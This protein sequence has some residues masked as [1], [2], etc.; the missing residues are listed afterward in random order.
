MHKRYKLISD[1]VRLT[2]RFEE[3]VSDQELDIMNFTAWLND[4]VQGNEELAKDE[5]SRT[6]PA[7]SLDVQLSSVVG[8]LYRYAKHYSKKALKDSPL[9]TLDDYVFLATVMIK[10]GMTKSEVIQEHLLEITSGAEI[11]KRLQKHGFIEDYENP[12]DKRSKKLKVTSAG[13]QALQTAQ[14]DMS[15]AAQIV[16][17]N[18]SD[19][20]KMRVLQIGYKLKAFHDEI[21]AEDKKSPL[22]DILDKYFE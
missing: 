16:G 1:L 17:G 9:T 21:H 11:L 5:N 14:A 6:Y 4:Q 10:P 8:Y 19:Q 22:K 12:D 3:E 2:A 20:E 13:M 15:Q 18:L 7:P